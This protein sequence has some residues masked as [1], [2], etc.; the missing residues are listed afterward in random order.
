MTAS[1]A[2]IVFSSLFLVGYWF[3]YT[4]LHILRSHY[5][6]AAAAEQARSNHLSF[7]AIRE[8][9]RSQA[10]DLP[11]PFL[12]QSLERDYRFVRFLLRHTP[13]SGAEVVETRI[14]MLDYCLMQ[15][16]YALTCRANRSQAC[17]ALEEMSGIVSYLAQKID[18]GSGSFQEA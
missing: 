17:K 9:L 15:C 6:E 16:W 3:R 7:P 11:L 8:R 18:A 12:H 5:N 13:R 14:L 10:R 4:C 1:G 2:L